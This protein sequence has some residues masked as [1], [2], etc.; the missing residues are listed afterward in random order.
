[1]P[2]GRGLDG[3]TKDPKL[4]TVE[5]SKLDWQAEVE[6]TGI[7]EELDQAGKSS[8][9]YLGRREFLDRVETGR[10]ERDRAERLKGKG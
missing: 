3:K 9:D 7:R 10:D 8:K 2:K 1:M 6:R 5:K 4:N